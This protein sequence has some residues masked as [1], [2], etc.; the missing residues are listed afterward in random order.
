MTL[1][2]SRRRRVLRFVGRWGAFFLLLWVVAVVVFKLLEN[3]MIY[4]GA[5]GRTAWVDQPDKRIEDVWLTAADGTRLGAR[6]LSADEQTGAVLLSHGNG[7]NVSRYGEVMHYL[8]KHLGR[9]VLVY[10]YPGYGLSEGKPTEAGCYAAGEAAY[11]Y[12]TD[13]RG[14]PPNRIVLLGESLGGGV[15][16]ELATRHDHVALVLLYPFTSL[17][18]AAKWHYPFLPCHT[19]M[20][21]RYDNLSKIGRCSRP[22]FILHGTADPVVPFSQGE[23]L[24]QA[25]NEPKRLRAIEGGSHEPDFGDAVYAELRQFLD[26]PR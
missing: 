24:Y 12:L 9:S 14:V 11:R 1:V 18:A 23:R 8:R 10:D 17:P 13:T 22:L 26:E 15:S 21:N 7:G 6:Y 19:F 20:A 5:N 2:P 3:R 16:V 25:A 4:A